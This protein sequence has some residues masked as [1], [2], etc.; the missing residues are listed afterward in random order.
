MNS[1]NVTTTVKRRASPSRRRFLGFTLVE[2]LLGM[3]LTILVGGVLYLMQS[4]GLQAVSKGTTR[5]TMHSEI[6]R[7]LERMVA[8]LRSAQEI[9]E[10]T[11]DSIRIS[12]F[13]VTDDEG[14]VGDAALIPVT[15]LVQK[16][17]NAD[18]WQLIRTENREPP[19]EILDGSS[20]EIPMFSAYYLEEASQENPEPLFQEFDI[21]ENA[22]DQRKRICFIRIN[23]KLRQGKEFVNINTAVT[24]RGAYQ[25][26]LQPSWKLR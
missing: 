12:K 21:Q 8:D 10:I 5:L 19:M 16:V 11:E 3:S 9:L 18:R 2:L 17:K 7:K 15:Y 1:V 22:S 4:T 26:L 14:E 13:A 6:R 24:M 23:L 25:R 20:I